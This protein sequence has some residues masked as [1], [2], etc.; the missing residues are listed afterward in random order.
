LV[1]TTLNWKI[2]VYKSFC[3]VDLHKFQKDMGLSKEERQGLA[4][5]AYQN[6]LDRYSDGPANVL[7]GARD[8]LKAWS[9]K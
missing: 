6:L 9:N 5:E 8:K 4:I 1:W 3:K 2:W 7:Q